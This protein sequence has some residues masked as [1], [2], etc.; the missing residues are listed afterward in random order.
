[1]G[2]AEPLVISHTW[3]SSWIANINIT[4]SISGVVTLN[5]DEFPNPDGRDYDL[6][7]QTSAMTE[8][9]SLGQSTNWQETSFASLTAGETY[10]FSVQVINSNVA[11][12]TSMSE[13]VQFIPTGP[14]FNVAAPATPVAVIAGGSAVANVTVDTPLT[15][16]PGTVKLY[17][18]NRSGGIGLQSSTGIYAPTL[19]GTTIPVTLTAAANL[20]SGN[21]TATVVAV[22]NGISKE[23]VVSVT[24]TAPSFEYKRCKMN[25]R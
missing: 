16:Y 15:N 10:T 8:T 3:P 6:R 25:R 9:A 21:Y 2:A 1:M 20:P 5:W 11:T 7:F 14:E 4:E 22:S 19:G 23:S 12:Q 24:V 18:G 13:M 17:P